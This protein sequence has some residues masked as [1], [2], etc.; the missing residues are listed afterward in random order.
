MPEALTSSPTLD[1]R[2][3]KHR[4]K[5]EPPLWTVDQGLLLGG[6]SWA[7][8]P[9]AGKQGSEGGAV[10]EEKGVCGVKGVCKV[11]EGGEGFYSPG[12]ASHKRKKTRA[13]R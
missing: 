5:K 8:L 9:G 4:G 7:E 1:A 11:C 12:R 6:R 10:C 3:K 13:Q 2:C